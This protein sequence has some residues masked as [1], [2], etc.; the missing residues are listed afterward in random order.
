MKFQEIDL[1]YDF[2]IEGFPI[3]IEVIFKHEFYEGKLVNRFQKLE[4]ENYKSFTP[5]GDYWEFV[6]IWRKDLVFTENG[7]PIEDI[8]PYY[9]AYSKGFLDGY[10]EFENEIKELN[11]I[12][13]PTPFPIDKIFKE[14]KLEVMPFSSRGY[15]YK[16]DNNDAEPIP[17]MKKDLLFEG[18]AKVGRNYKAWFYIIKNPKPFIPLFRRFYFESYKFYELQFRKRN[19]HIENYS[20]ELQTVIDE[21]ERERNPNDGQNGQL[22]NKFN[23]MPLEDVKNF[24]KVLTLKKNPKGKIWMSES[25]FET[26]IKRSFGLQTDLEK[27][28]INIGRGGKYALV[29]L[30]WMYYNLCQNEDIALNR[31]KAPYYE[32][33][34]NAFYTENFDDLRIDNFKESNSDYDWN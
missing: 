11:Q 7:E 1:I 29:K 9:E 32:L 10:F 19:S 31:L 34:K 20:S 3:E 33:L 27:P 16:D 14:I 24:F 5:Y 6:G 8:I 18:G 23:S 17:I 28:S 4:G 25:D 22:E 21:I 30:F 12:F 13:G 26:F 15:V 2:P